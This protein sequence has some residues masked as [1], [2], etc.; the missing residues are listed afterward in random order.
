VLLKHVQTVQQD[1]Q[2]LPW[3]L[4]EPGC[5]SGNLVHDPFGKTIHGRDSP[6]SIG[7]VYRIG[8]AGLAWHS[9]PVPTWARVLRKCSPAEARRLGGPQFRLHPYYYV[10]LVD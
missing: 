2:Q 8:E 7:R 1:L 10:V 4:L 3:V 5:S 9:E 6:L